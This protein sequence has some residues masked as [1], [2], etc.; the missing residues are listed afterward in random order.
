MAVPPAQLDVAAF[1]GALA[2]GPPIETHISAVFVGKDEV[3]KMKKAVRL[4]FLDFTDI[5]AR[6]HFLCRELDLNRPD[7][8]DIYRDVVAVDRAEDG[9]LV[10]RPAE[11][12]RAPVDWVLRMA[13]IP[14]ADFLD[15][16]A[17]RG[18]LTTDLLVALGD[19]VARYHRARA[20]VHGWNSP[21]AI[22]RVAAGCLVSARAAGLPASDIDRWDDGMRVALAR[23]A[24]WLSARA[25]A[26]FVRR[27]HGDLHLGNLCLWHGQPVPFDALEFDEELATS[28]VSYD[29]A[30]LLMDLDRRVGRAAANRV[31]NRYIARTGDAG[32]S[33]GSPIL[34]SLRA[35]I[36]AHVQA[37]SGDVAAARRYLALALDYLRPAAPIVLAIGGMPGAGKS[38]LAGRLAPLLGRPPGAVWLRSDEIR[39]RA[40]G[41]APEQA[42]PAAAYSQAENIAVSTELVELA[43]LVAG[44]GHAVIADATFMDTGHRHA[45][46]EAARAAR[47]PFMGIWLTA[48]GDVLERRVRGR[49][50]D[51]SDATPAVLRSALARDPGAGDW[52]G[53]DGT[54]GETAFV[55]VSGLAGAPPPADGAALRRA[56]P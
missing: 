47:V 5:A 17:D 40:F 37:A 36:R 52:L 9:T 39:K 14:P 7:A 43:R 16:V 32:L 42:L 51:A 26:G 20:P 13:P 1:L 30:F 10:L 48:P 24:A 3:W 53:V 4:S 54:D 29:L 46:A 11:Q 18:A 34:M 19:C 22:G 8:P 56:A 21:G 2:G 12:S 45:I 44:G 50:N 33:C 31:F 35:M 27:G 55:R 6:H 49:R 41:V 15:K 38:T 23:S 28:D 25:A